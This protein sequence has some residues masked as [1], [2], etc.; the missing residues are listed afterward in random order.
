MGT[1]NSVSSSP[2]SMKWMR[3]FLILV[4]SVVTFILSFV[5]MGRI[6]AIAVTVWQVTMLIFTIVGM[7]ICFWIFKDFSNGGYSL[8]RTIGLLSSSLIVWTLTY[9]KIYRFSQIGIFVALIIVLVGSLLYKPIRV[10]MLKKLEQDD[11]IR[12]ILI[13]EFIFSVLLVVLCFYK[14]MYPDINGQE[15]F[16]NYGFLLSMLKSDKL[17]ANDMWLAGKSIN[18][19]YYGQFVYAMIAKFINFSPAY[20]YV[21]GLCTSIAI[22]FVSAYCIGYELISMAI[23]KGARIPKFATIVCGLLTGF[24]TVIFGNSHS[25][26]YDEN[27][28]GNKLLNSFSKMGID[29]GSTTGFFYPDSTR[30]I[31]H[32]PD[33]YKVDA[34]TGEVLCNGDYTIHEFPFYS[35]LVGDLHAHVISMM[36]VTLIAAITIALVYRVTNAS[37]YERNNIPL[38]SFVDQEFSV[39]TS[40]FSKTNITYELRMLMSFELVAIAIALGIAQMTNYWDFLIYFIFCAMAFLVY[41]TTRS[42]EFITIVSGLFFVINLGLIL[43]IYMILGE[44]VLLHAILQVV[45]LAIS[46][47]FCL[48]APSALT[49]TSL[50]MSFLFAASTIIAMPFNWNFDMISNKLAPVQNRTS[51]YQFMILWCVHFTICIAFIVFTILTKNYISVKSTGKNSR[52]QKSYVINE[53]SE[54]FTNVVAKF[55]GQRNTADIFACGM[56]ITGFLMIA[57][58]EIIYV[59]DIYTGG[60]LRA[61]TMFKFTFAGFIILSM[62][63]AYAVV[64]L[65]WF[66]KKSGEYSGVAF[67]ISIVCALLLFIPAHYTYL[68]LDQRCGGLNLDNFKT[69]DGT[70]YLETYQ[71]PDVTG[72]PGNL[73]DYKHTIDWINSNIKGC[74]NIVESYGNS[75]TDHDIVSAYTGLPTIFGWQT[76]EWLW[77]YHGIV[78]KETDLLVSD[79]E[80]DVFELYIN[81]R[82]ADVDTIYT[83]A[84]TDLVKQT[85]AK[86][87]V[88]YII[89]GPIEFETYGYIN[90]DTF[91]K[92]ADVVYESGYVRVYK[93]NQ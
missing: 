10:N 51:F 21:I 18:Y 87:D 49:R 64:R 88:S 78:D 53:P 73:I 37:E 62:V 8:S 44:N 69:L 90:N 39:N 59:R 85:L 58:P 70:E 9:I 67:G 56:A 15:K 74:P 4:P 17:P 22:P 43:G 84:D 28:V 20:T 36:V 35:Y 68:S 63:I 81:P 80:K 66:T 48:M 13:E 5:L 82:H 2:K 25:F 83:S 57:A 71:S 54:G 60:Y 92:I 40:V 30:F 38:F 12:N 77:R 89:S 14:G 11:L 72:N 16:M 34:I 3:L 33:S 29:V 47:M 76:H 7:P 52:K 65:F 42:K 32:N 50:S 27:S 46:F 91:D 61:N 45:V 6:D 31:G 86:Y 55:F 79:P 1:K 24:T 93:V 23:S 26:F 19:Y 75:Y 41:N